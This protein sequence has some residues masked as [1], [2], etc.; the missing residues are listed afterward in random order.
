MAADPFQGF[1]V[2]YHRH[3]ILAQLHIQFYAIGSLLLRQSKGLQGIFRRIAA[4]ASVGENFCLL[5]VHS[6]C[7][8]RFLSFIIAVLRKKGTLCAGFPFP[9]LTVQKCS[10]QPLIRLY[11]SMVSLI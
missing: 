5:H 2:K 4:G 11:S 7:K 8:N 10:R 6:S 3:P 9:F 1:I